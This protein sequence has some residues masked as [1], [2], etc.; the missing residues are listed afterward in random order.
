MCAPFSPL[1]N[2][3]SLAP[4]LFPS[5]PLAFSLG[6]G[7]ASAMVAGAPRHLCLGRA[8]PAGVCV[9]HQV[10]SLGLGI[11]VARMRACMCVGPQMYVC[12]TAVNRGVEGCNV[13]VDF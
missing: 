8:G 3:P 7:D 13:C 11:R 12:R 2:F 1:P 6:R 5:L 10:S 9:G 4:S